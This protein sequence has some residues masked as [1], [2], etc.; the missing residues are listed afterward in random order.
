MKVLYDHQIFIAQKYGGISRYFYELIKSFNNAKD[1]DVSTSVLFSKNHYI[2]DKKEINHIKGR[3]KIYH[4]INNA[5]LLNKLKKQNFDVFH[6]TYYDPYFLQYIINKPF[7]LTVHDMIHEKFKESF[8]KDDRISQY[9]QMLVKKASKIIAVSQCTKNDL[10]DILG[11]I[12]EKI[13]VVYH[14][15]SMVRVEK[16]LNIKQKKYILFVGSRW[17]YKNFDKFITASCKILQ[18]NHNISVVCAGGGGE[19]NQEELLLFKKLKIEKKVFQYTVNDEILSQLYQNALVFVFPSL[20]EG[21]GIPIL[22]A[23]ACKC[24]VACSNVSSL[25]EI[26]GNAVEYFNPYDEASIYT[27][28]NN[29]LSNAEYKKTLVS[30]GLQ[31]LNKFSWEQT[32]IDTKKIYESVIQ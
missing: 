11:I 30:N 28:I 10:I 4:K 24:P 26:A 27:A 19:F 1:M 15:N 22:E 12:P 16:S 9:K 5:I 6:P 8:S 7:V 18:K 2:A 14:G 21:F 32:A 25:P 23:F 29:V 17:G 3:R 20:Y 31:R 13:E